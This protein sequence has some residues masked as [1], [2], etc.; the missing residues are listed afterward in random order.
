MYEILKMNLPFMLGALVFAAII[1]AWPGQPRAAKFAGYFIGFIA[2]CFFWVQLFLSF[3]REMGFDF[4]ESYAAGIYALIL[5]IAVI[6]VGMVLL[7]IWM[8]CFGAGVASEPED[9][10]EE[11]ICHDAEKR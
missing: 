1:L 4:G 8:V 7:V 11:H 2:G 10:R 9:E 3:A 6:P 5:N